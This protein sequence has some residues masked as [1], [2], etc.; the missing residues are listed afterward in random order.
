MTSPDTTAAAAPAT[1]LDPGAGGDALEVVRIGNGEVDLAFLP[2]VGA[3]LISVRVAGVELLWHN[4]DHLDAD[5]RTVLPRSAWPVLDGT[6]GSWANLGGSKTWPAPQGWS[7]PDEWPGPPDPVLDSGVWTWT[8][9]RRPD[10]TVVTFTSP[11]DPWTGLR[12]VRQVELPSAGT[13][14]D[15]RVRFRNVSER[16]VAWAVWEVCQVDTEAFA[17]PATPGHEAGLWVGASGQADPVDMVSLPDPIDV[18]PAEAGRRRVAVADVVAKVGF[19]DATGTFELVRPDGARL[20]WRYAVDA[21]AAYPDGGCRAEVWMQY[22]TPGPVGGGLHPTARLLELEALS[23]LR[24]L[25]PGDELG[26][27]IAWSVVGPT[28]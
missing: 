4:P 12:V 22:P 5:L 8:L 10:A 24:T 9:E 7:G 6:M 1:A 13:R 14:F 20:A 19:P 28:R 21:A 11:D 23:P 3:R 26:L 17:G 15:L 25:A 27:D 2:G 16:T 18:G